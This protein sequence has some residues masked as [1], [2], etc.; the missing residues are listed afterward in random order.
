MNVILFDDI[1]RERLLPFTYI[2]TQADIR[3]GILTIRE[4]WEKRLKTKT[5]S[6]TETYLSEKF[7]LKISEKNVFISGSICPNNALIEAISLLKLGQT[8]VK[9][10]FV[11]AHCLDTCPENITEYCGE[12]IEFKGNCLIISHLWE[13]FVH[14]EEELHA[15]FEILTK[16]RKS[17]S[18]SKTN[19]LIGNENNIFIEK[20]AV[21]EASTFNVKNSKIYIGKEAE[22]MEGSL[23]RGS[24][25]LCEGSQLKLGAKVY[26]PTTIGPHSKVG[27][28]VNNVVIFGY[29][30]KAHD[31]FMGNS[32][33]GEWC[34]I[35]ADTNTS[36]LKNDYGDVKLWNY[37]VQKFQKTG[38]Q[39]CG[40]IMG[41]HVKCGINT[42]FN[43]GSVIGVASNLFGGD[44]MPNFVSSFMW[45]GPS[46][47]QE[48]RPEKILS[49]A[50]KAYKRRHVVFDETE[51]KI[52]MEVFYNVKNKKE[53]QFPN[54]Y[55][56]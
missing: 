20:G 24:F 33:I 51:K 35:G 11:I 47:F 6:L 46:G 19:T 43:T 8:L 12:K 26:G 42:M 15:D 16:G 4:K 7:P 32:V 37:A 48:A 40:L 9:E 53:P 14:N 27:G 41:D 23:I 52:L 18:L 36:N 17:E 3:I 49:I 25:A 34:N 38:L 2:R 5:S 21:I 50:E 30:N 13:I 44:Y 54:F 39:F 10:D 29:S 56:I 31:G 55:L 28:E 1:N 45:G 22:I